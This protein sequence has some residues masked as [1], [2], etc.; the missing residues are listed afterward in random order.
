[1][2]FKYKYKN[3]NNEKNEKNTFLWGMFGTL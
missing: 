1:M 3:T 2:N